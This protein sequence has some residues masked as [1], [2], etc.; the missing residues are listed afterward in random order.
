MDE[1][2]ELDLEGAAEGAVSLE[3]VLKRLASAVAGAFAVGKLS[4]Y[5]AEAARAGG[6][7]DKEL[8][9]LRLALG[10]LRA[11][12]G[13]AAAPIGEVFIPMLSSA[14]FAVTRAVKWIG[15]IISALFGGSAGMDAMAD[16]ADTAASAVT[17]VGKAVK[18][19]LAGF[20]ELERLDQNSGSGGS[21]GATTEAVVNNYV[22]QLDLWQRMIVGK[23][24]GLIE[25]LKNIDFSA[26]VAAFEALKA[27]IA[28]IG[29]ALFAGLEWAWHNLLVP[30]AQWTAEDV[31]PAF[32]QLLAGA[33]EV[34]GAVI[35][36]VKPLF[37]WLWENFLQPVAQWTGGVIVSVLE[38]LTERLKG[39]SAW[40]SE[41]Q[42]AVQ[43]MTAVA[44]AFLAVWAGGQVA[45]WLRE[46]SPLSGFFSSLIGTVLSLSGAVSLLGGNFF[47]L[48]EAAE[49]AWGGI[50]EALQKG[51]GWVRESFLSPLTAG[52]K[53]CVNGIIGFVNGLLTSAVSGLN[54]LIRGI[55]K[56][57]FTVP[58]W[59]PVYGGKTL[60][61]SLSSLSVPRVPYL[62]QGAVLPANKPFL[63]VVGDQKSGTNVEA[64]L[65]TI[66]EAVAAVLSQQL[67]GMMAGFS[68]VVRA[69]QEKEGSVVIG[70]DVIYAAAQRYGS[71]L[72]VA[73]GGY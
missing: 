36:A 59:V 5:L 20:D 33:A 56:I 32:L 8:L 2:M 64:P 43:A 51:I 14:V 3:R 10:K 50:R 16:S 65:S 25:P 46:A 28:P 49:T 12:V 30:L 68:A 23:I 34:L 15:Q 45:K 60:G 39:V 41:N 27:A 13:R 35:T 9:V 1:F 38:R 54:A 62:A 17:S 6:E 11:A 29:R 44:A 31:L 37:I 70:D 69:I 22:N 66:Q 4:E 53:S 63:A 52:V 61:F 58:G 24:Q 71:K 57:S 42:P 7:L 26:A 73:K 47:G 40:I 19:S 21:A 72:A 18:R 67:S 48:P 55:N